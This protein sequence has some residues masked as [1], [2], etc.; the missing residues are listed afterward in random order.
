M[1]K[2]TALLL[3]LC[4]SA[5]WANQPFSED[6]TYQKDRP[7]PAMEQLTG[8]TFVP[9]AY[10][11]GISAKTTVEAGDIQIHFADHMV[12]FKGIKGLYNF[13]I[14]A[15]KQ[16]KSGYQFDLVNR[17]GSS[18]GFA[19]LKV[20]LDEE[21]YAKAI[22]IYA[23]SYGEYTFFLPTK[24]DFQ[25]QQEQQ[26]FTHQQKLVIDSLS[27]LMAA[28]IMP[29]QQARFHKEKM[30]IKDRISMKKGFSFTFSPKTVSLQLENE[31][32][33]YRIKRIKEKPYQHADFPSIQSVV[34]IK[35]KE[36]PKHIKVYLN[37]QQE[38]AF[39]EMSN[40]RYFLMSAHE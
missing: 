3:V 8:Y 25:L 6:Y 33:N 16:T 10:I 31:Q 19:K 30:G 32:E 11:E 27:Q 20:I 28:P 22:Y 24:T 35:I 12:F 7:F 38:I 17:R 18:S 39:I 21:Q 9:Q 4:C 5:L 14:M 40:I 13:N 2:F 23:H 29:Y 37:K 26:Y 1:K 36:K 15:K 34:H